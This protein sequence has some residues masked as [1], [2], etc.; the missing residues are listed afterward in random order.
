MGS[1][2]TFNGDSRTSNFGII[3]PVVSSYSTTNCSS[4]YNSTNNDNNQ[5][6]MDY[7]FQ[8][9]VTITLNKFDGTAMSNMQHYA[10]YLNM[11]GITDEEDKSDNH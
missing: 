10:L 5:F 3:Y 7:P 6:Y 2:Y 1:G 4:Y 11:V 9:Q 8:N